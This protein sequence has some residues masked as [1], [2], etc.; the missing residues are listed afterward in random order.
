MI[1]CWNFLFRP[2]A[3][4]VVWT[5]REPGKLENL[6]SAGFRGAIY[7]V[8]PK[9]QEILGLKDYP[10]VSEIPGEVE[11]AVI[12][13][14]A[15]LVPQ[16]IEECGKKGVRAAVILS[17]AFRETGREGAGRGKSLFWTSPPPEVFQSSF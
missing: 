10:S 2:K 13:I 4:A 11:L 7:P 5:S 14:R 16:V 17:A 8:N 3:V 1:L 9:A 6:L 12:A 15:P